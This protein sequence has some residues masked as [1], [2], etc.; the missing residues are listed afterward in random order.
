[1]T[2]IRK[3]A[4]KLSNAHE[5]SST[6]T[7]VYQNYSQKVLNTL[8]ECMSWQRAKFKYCK[9]IITRFWVY[10]D[11]LANLTYFTKSSWTNKEKRH[12]L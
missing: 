8:R 3:I 7:K 6:K 12:Q 2:H 5:K 9:N 10:D 11:E 4:L 1:M